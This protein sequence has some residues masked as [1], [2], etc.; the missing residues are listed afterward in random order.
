MLSARDAHERTAR[1]AETIGLSSDVAAATSQADATLDM[2]T[3]CTPTSQLFEPARWNDSV[4]RINWL[5]SDPSGMTTLA[6]CLRALLVTEKRYA[7]SDIPRSAFKATMGFFPRFIERSR[8]T[9]GRPRF[10]QEF[11]VPRLISMTLLR[12]EQLEFE[13]CEGADGP[14]VS[15]H[16]PSDAQLEAGLLVKTFERARTFLTMMH[17]QYAKVDFRC[18]SWL[19]D[20]ALE[21]LLRRGSRI[22]MFRSLFTLDGLQFSDDYKQWICGR[23]DIADVDLPEST[24]LERGIKA[25]VLSGGRM[26]IGYGTLDWH[27]VAQLR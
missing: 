24:S 5:N 14:F 3:L 10:D 6:C 8:A 15:V 4:A 1:L 2:V 7:M 20:P 26:A 23:T 27:R 12:I 16:I 21:P 13:M 25:H 22:R 19:L 17:P 11:W 18:D 9:Y